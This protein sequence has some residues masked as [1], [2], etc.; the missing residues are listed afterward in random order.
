MVRL[1]LAKR[2]IRQLLHPAFNQGSLG[3]LVLSSHNKAITGI[4]EG[5]SPA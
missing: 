4:A 2:I 5:L 1:D 3:D